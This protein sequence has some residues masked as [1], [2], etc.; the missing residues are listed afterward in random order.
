MLTA[1]VDSC[2]GSVDG[3]ERGRKDEHAVHH[4]CE[5]HC[6]RY[7]PSGCYKSVSVYAD[8][9]SVLVK[10]NFLYA[11]ELETANGQFLIDLFYVD[12]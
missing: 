6:E 10:Q 5:L 11:N 1:A 12:F 8:I 9:L 3:Q 7:P 2:L 4:F